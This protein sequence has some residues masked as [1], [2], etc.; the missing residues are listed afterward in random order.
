MT[1]SSD[2]EMTR[3]WRTSW[4]L[5]IK[6]LMYKDRSNVDNLL[7]YLLTYPP[8]HPL[9]YLLFPIFYNLFTILQLAYYLPCNSTMIWINMWNKKLEK[10]WTPFN[11][12]IHWWQLSFVIME[13]K[14]SILNTCNLCAFL[15]A[16]V[17][18]LD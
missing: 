5:I 10:N 14:G 2:C 6:W 3:I 9:T 17:G 11:G 15:R 12:V 1:I 8:T 16:K 4:K 7:I 18:R 13:V